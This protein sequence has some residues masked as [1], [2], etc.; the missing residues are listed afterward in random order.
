MKKWISLCLAVI[1]VVSFIPLSV[2]EASAAAIT[3]EVFA[4]KIAALR[5]T[6]PEGKRWNKLNG[7]DSEGIAKAGDLVCSGNVLY[8]DG[9]LKARTLSRL[10]LKATDLGYIGIEITYDDTFTPSITN[11]VVT[12]K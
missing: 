7:L 8:S 9:T 5:N 2:F 4:A 11:V 3:E 6:Y 1:L 10:H 12:P